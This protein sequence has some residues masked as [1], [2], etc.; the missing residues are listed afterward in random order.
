MAAQIRAGGGAHSSSHLP[1]VVLN[2]LTGATSVHINAGFL[3]LIF[4]RTEF[5]KMD[6]EMLFL[7]LEL[8]SSLILI[9]RLMSRTQS[10]TAR[11]S[12]KG[13]DRLLIQTLLR[14]DCGGFC[15]N[16]QDVQ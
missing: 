10:K 11:D 6:W 12:G 9:S 13:C 8:L 16:A 3:S 4:H 1:H 15:G 2:T 7:L 14:P 5:M